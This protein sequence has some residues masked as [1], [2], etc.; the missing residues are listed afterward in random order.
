MPNE[1]PYIGSAVLALVTA[2]LIECA[3]VPL[4]RERIQ[5]EERIEEM[6]KT[7][8]MRRESIRQV[9]AGFCCFSFDRI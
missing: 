2:T 1:F 7:I 5:N 3:V 6:S 9:M 4:I 8:K